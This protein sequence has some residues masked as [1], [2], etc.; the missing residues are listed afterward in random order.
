MGNKVKFQLVK[1]NVYFR[2]PC[3]ICGG[4]TEKI[5]TL[6]EVRMGA[7]KGLRV[8]EE[9]LKAGADQVDAR[10]KEHVALLR[11]YADTLASLEGHVEIPTFETWQAAEDRC[12]DIPF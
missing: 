7:H 9:C 3:D 12:N 1:T 8:C 5:G 10:L 2:W 4:Q 11:E 6:C